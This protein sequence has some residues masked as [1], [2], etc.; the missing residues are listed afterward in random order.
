MWIVIVGCVVA[1]L[2]GLALWAALEVVE[3]FW[4][5]EEETHL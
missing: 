2:C 5:G 3:P 4:D 1:L